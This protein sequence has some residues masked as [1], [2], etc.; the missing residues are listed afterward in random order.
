MNFRCC[1]IPITSSCL[2]RSRHG[3]VTDF[4]S[5]I[6]LSWTQVFGPC[7]R[8]A[9]VYQWRIL[10][11]PSK[12]IDFHNLLYQAMRTLLRDTGRDPNGLERMPFG[13][14]L[15]VEDLAWT[16]L[17]DENPR[18]GSACSRLTHLLCTALSRGMDQ[19]WQT[20][21]V[22]ARNAERSRSECLYEHVGHWNKHEFDLEAREAMLP[23]PWQ[24]VNRI[25]SVMFK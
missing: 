2:S 12:S 8:T 20:R 3:R 6:S 16:Y 21:V 1:E 22:R 10:P 17:S 19:R 18:L 14:Y 23:I 25:M 15:R 24:G 4:R 7:D 11:G 13:T 5:A 9:T